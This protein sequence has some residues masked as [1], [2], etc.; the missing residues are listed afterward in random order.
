LKSLSGSHTGASKDHKKSTTVT[1]CI[2]KLTHP[3]NCEN[4][5]C[6]PCTTALPQSVSSIAKYIAAAH[7]KRW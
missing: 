7:M 4:C 6:C 1:H 3:L 2:A 5:N